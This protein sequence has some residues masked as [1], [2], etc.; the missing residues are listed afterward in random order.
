MVGAI[1]QVLVSDPSPVIR[2][3][4]AFVLATTHSRKAAIMLRNAIV[5]DPSPLVQ[6]EAIEALGDLLGHKAAPFLAR[7]RN[8]RDP[9]IRDTVSVMLGE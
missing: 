5:Q 2:H 8:S 6:H 3:E 4:A 1:S 7:L 9:I